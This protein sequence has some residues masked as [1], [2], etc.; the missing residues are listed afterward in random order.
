[1][2]GDDRVEETRGESETQVLYASALANCDD[3]TVSLDKFADDFAT[4][5]SR[6]DWDEISKQIYE[7][8]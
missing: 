5:R 6:S 2:E 7:E 4:L 1:M 3:V 8:H